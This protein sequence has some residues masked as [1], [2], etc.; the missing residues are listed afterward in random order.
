MIGRTQLSEVEHDEEI[1]AQNL[2]DE[3]EIRRVVDE[4][5]NCCDL[6]DWK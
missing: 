2:H 4:I 3:A 1:I 6:K 5:D